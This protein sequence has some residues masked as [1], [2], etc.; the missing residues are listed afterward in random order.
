MEGRRPAI[1]PKVRNHPDFPLRKFIICP[2]CK[3]KLTG[4]WS[5]GRTNKY[6]YYRCTTK[7][8]NLSVRKEIIDEK[9]FKILKSIQPKTEVLKLFEAIVIDVWKSKQ[10][11]AET[12]KTTLEKE[13]KGL[14]EKKKKIEDLLIAGSFDAETYKTRSEEIQSE[15]MLK[16]LALNEQ[17][18]EC[19]DIESCLNY[20]KYFLSNIADLWQNADLSLKQ[21]FQSLIFPEGLYFDGKKFETTK[22]AYIFKQFQE[23]TFQMNRLGSVARRS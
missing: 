13:L 16:K 15:M 20:C 19:N 22:I 17:I 23:N 3:K 1:V 8:C 5:K 6:P 2:K 9:F 11:G 4:S 14:Q 21:R 12:T 18:I 10:T 7:E